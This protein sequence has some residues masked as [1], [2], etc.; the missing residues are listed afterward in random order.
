VTPFP[1]TGEQDAI[2]DAIVTAETGGFDGTL[3]R[4]ALLD[5][6]AGSE[7]RDRLIGIRSQA[8]HVV[9]CWRLTVGEGLGD[10]GVTATAERRQHL[11]SAIAVLAASLA[12]ASS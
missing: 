8:E 10:R 11:N 7:Q 3:A 4:L 9:S 5:L 6:R 12:E 2:L 1:S